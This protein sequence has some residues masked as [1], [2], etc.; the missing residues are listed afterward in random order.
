MLI[1]V[2]YV[3]ARRVLRASFEPL[4]AIVMIRIPEIRD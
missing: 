2:K 4:C 3:A 1:L